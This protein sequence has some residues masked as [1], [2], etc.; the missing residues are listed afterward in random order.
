MASE[1]KLSLGV[2]AT[3]YIAAVLFSLS[4]LLFIIFN[5]YKLFTFI[6]PA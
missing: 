3:P 6:S 2:A 1:K 4:P 5:W